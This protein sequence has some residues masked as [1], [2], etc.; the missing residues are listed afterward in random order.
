MLPL[1]W[2]TI[3]TRDRCLAG[4]SYATSAKH[5]HAQQLP[6][7]MPPLAASRFPPQISPPTPVQAA[8]RTTP[9]S[10]RDRSLDEL[11]SDFLTANAPPAPGPADQDLWLSDPD[12]WVAALGRLARRRAW[13][14]VVDVAGKM[15]ATHE[16][17]GASSLTAEQVRDH[18]VISGPKPTGGSFM[19][20]AV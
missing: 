5:Y 7:V 3:S 15:L 18:T 17:G 11:V 10:P 9:A 13:A 16:Q 2:T 19:D 4:S 6:R 14:S 12:G 20:G 8:F 1:L